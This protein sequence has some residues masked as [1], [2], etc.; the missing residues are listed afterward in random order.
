MVK[1]LGFQDIDKFLLHLNRNI[2]ESGVGDTPIFVPFSLEKPMDFFTRKDAILE[3]WKKPLSEPKWE[4]AWGVFEES[5][6]IAHLD[7]RTGTTES[8]L[9]RAVIGMG[10][11]LSYRRKGL[12]KLLM[13]SAVSWAKQQDH[14][15]WLDLKVFVLNTPAKKF[16]DHMGFTTLGRVEDAFRVN[17][18]KIDDFHMVLK[19][20]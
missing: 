3:R 4:R 7:L 1:L 9:H 17:G 6:I 12:G 10:I 20:R 16:Y 13:N 15:A 8:E 19:L 2:A 11:E 18:Q 5:Q 14:L